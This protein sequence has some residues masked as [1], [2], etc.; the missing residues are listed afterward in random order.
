MISVQQL[1]EASSSIASWTFDGTGNAIGSTSGALD[2]FIS[3]GSLGMTV[4]EST[5]IAGTSTFTPGGGVF[6]DALAAI[7]SGQQGTN[8]LTSFR[9]LHVNLRTSAG[10]ELG[11]SIA[12]SFYTTL[13]DGT[14]QIYVA[15]SS[16]AVAAAHPALSVGLSPNSPLPAGTNALGSVT[17]GAGTAAI[18]TVIVAQPGTATLTQVTSSTSSQTLVAANASRKGL[19]VYNSATKPIYIAFA[20][21]AT[22]TV[23]TYEIL[24]GNALELNANLAYSGLISVIGATGITGSIQVTDL[25]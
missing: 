21:T 15:P 4:D 1:N 18:G 13:S 2:V 23:F 25:N 22:T 3:G 11:N 12:D 24:A 7:T 16:T 10:I 17:I 20:A 5:F 19:V 8:R 6:N 9:A 14:T